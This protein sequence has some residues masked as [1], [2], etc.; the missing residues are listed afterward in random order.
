MTLSERVECIEAHHHRMLG[1]NNLEQA[2]AYRER[3]DAHKSEVLRE[4]ERVEREI[5][6]T[7][8]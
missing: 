7:M 3:I 6:G 2:E 5:L 4:I 1:C 8:N